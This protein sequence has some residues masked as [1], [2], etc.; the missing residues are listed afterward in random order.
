M[1]DFF[2][3]LK[4]WYASRPAWLRA[5]I[6][7]LVAVVL[8]LSTLFGTTSCGIFRESRVEYRQKKHVERTDSLFVTYPRSATYTL[9]TRSYEKTV[10]RM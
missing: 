3:K 9:Q 10:N 1:T 7:A 2:Q 8:V 4:E 6:V 5:L